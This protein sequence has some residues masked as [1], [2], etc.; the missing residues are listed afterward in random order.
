M[1][2]KYKLFRIQDILTDL[3]FSFQHPEI[4]KNSPNAFLI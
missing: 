1:N 4:V 2:Y 3:Q